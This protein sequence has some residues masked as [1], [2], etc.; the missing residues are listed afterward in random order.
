MNTAGSPVRP[1]RFDRGPGGPN[2]EL[3]PCE[4]RRSMKRLVIGLSGFVALLAA[5]AATAHPLGN[6]TINRFSRIEVS[7]PRVYVVYVLDMAE[8]PTFQAGTIDAAAY[9][10]RIAANVHLTVDG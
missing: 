5:A 10:R 4:L 7:G 3:A 1:D 2:R 9:S 8:I 6:F